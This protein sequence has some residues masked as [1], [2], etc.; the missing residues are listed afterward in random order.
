[1]DLYELLGVPPTAGLDEIKRAYRR[2][3]RRYHPDINPGDRTAVAHFRAV[4]DAYEVLT[5]PDRRREYDLLGSA[6]V[7]LE[8]AAT[9]GFDGFDFSVHAADGSAASTF[10]DLFADVIHDAVSGSAETPTPGADLYL[11]VSIGFEEAVRGAEKALTVVRRDVCRGCRGR[12]VQPVAEA[13]CSSCRGA[14]TVRTAR[15]HMMFTKT[16][17]RCGGS[18]LLRHATCGGCNGL[19]VESRSETTTL[20]IPPGVSPGEQMRVPGLGHAGTRGAAPGDLCVTVQVAPHPVFRREGDDLFVTVPVAVHE[21]AL[22]ARFD[23]PTLDGP[24]RLRVPPGSQSGQ[25][26]RLRDRGVPGLRTGRRGDLIVEI[27]IVLPSVLDQRSR[28]LLH[29]FGLVN[30]ED[31]R[32]GLWRDASAS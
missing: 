25:R 19:G 11:T 31:V 18:G 13:T 8:S 4:A 14:G 3:A 7:V 10:G 29:E 22:G 9:F 17:G 24:A 20:T 21:A 23:I 5:D 27:R 16:C 6:G 15:G 1:M 28:E 2:L 32:A 30:I 26:F 12:G